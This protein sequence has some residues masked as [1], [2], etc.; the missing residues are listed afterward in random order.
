MKIKRDAFLY[1][2]GDDSDFAQCGTC[3]FGRDECAVM[4]GDEV[5]ARNGSCGL[6]AEGPELDYVVADLTQEDVG[7]VERQV[8]C[9]NCKFS[10][11]TTCNLFVTLNQTLPHL[12]ALDVK[13][14]PTACCNAQTPA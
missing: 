10:R 3:A 14:K 1:M 9:E 5:S 2:E 6:Y 4:G 11:G 7:Y 12:F 8:R 13:I